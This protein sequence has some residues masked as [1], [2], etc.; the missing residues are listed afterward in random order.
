MSWFGTPPAGLEL[1]HVGLVVP[2]LRA[3]MDTYADVLGFGWTEVHDSRID[4]LVDGQRREARIAATYSQQGPPYLEL[5]EELSGGVWG[6]SGLGLAHAGFWVDDLDGTALRWEAAGLPARVRHVPG[7][8]QAPLFTYHQA[9]P[10]MWWELVSTG[11]RERLD[12]RVRRA[13]EA[14]EP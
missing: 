5:V 4:V 7:A 2:D 12:A 11:F 1:Y 8:D 14:E 3:A 9:A 6:R 13:H 10:G